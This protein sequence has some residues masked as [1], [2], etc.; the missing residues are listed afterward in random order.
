MLSAKDAGCMRMVLSDFNSPL[1]YDAM[2][3]TL[4]DNPP[5]QADQCPCLFCEI[6][7]DFDDRNT[8]E[9]CPTKTTTHKSLRGSRES[10]RRWGKSGCLVSSSNAKCGPI[11]SVGDG[12][13]TRA[14]GP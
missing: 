2:E 11:D 7:T 14:V 8:V 1:E 10:L 5:G 13:V 12:T 4:S 6:D 9:S 3:E